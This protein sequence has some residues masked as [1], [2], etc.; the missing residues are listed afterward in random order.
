[1]QKCARNAMEK[2]EGGMQGVCSLLKLVTL[3]GKPDTK[4][5]FTLQ[6]QSNP[7]NKGC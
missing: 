1:M 5:V 3:V 2:E 6:D 4:G 7:S